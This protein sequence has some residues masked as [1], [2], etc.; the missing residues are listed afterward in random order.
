MTVELTVKTFGKENYF[1]WWKIKKMNIT[2]LHDYLCSLYLN[3]LYMVIISNSWL[4][5]YNNLIY[6]GALYR[7]S[8]NFHVGIFLRIGEIVAFHEYKFCEF[9]TCFHPLAII[10]V[11]PHPKH[12]FSG[13]HS[14][15]ETLEI[16]SWY[17][18]YKE[19][20]TSNGEDGTLVDSC[21]KGPGRGKHSSFLKYLKRVMWLLLVLLTIC[22]THNRIF[23]A[24]I[25]HAYNC[26]KLARDIFTI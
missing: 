16:D 18:V 22:H 8:G 25:Y 11:W 10:T 24:T 2:M 7:I 23:C 21:P 5:V 9:T 12:V 4:Q 13:L 14:T 1:V 15:M 3:Y 6:L 17:H 26:K 19:V 20:W